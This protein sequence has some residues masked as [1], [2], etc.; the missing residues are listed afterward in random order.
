MERSCQDLSR[1]ALRSG[2]GYEFQ[3][4]VT[5]CAD[6]GQDLD[7]KNRQINAKSIAVPVLGLYNIYVLEFLPV[8]F[9]FLL[10]STSITIVSFQQT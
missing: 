4:L 10:Q 8:C 7:R 1:V 5:V 3:D 9:E 6:V 2:S